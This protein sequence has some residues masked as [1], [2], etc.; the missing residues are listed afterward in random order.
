MG[1]GNWLPD[2]RPRL[3]ICFLHSAVLICEWRWM[4]GTYVSASSHLNYL[5]WCPKHCKHSVNA[6]GCFALYNAFIFVTQWGGVK[7]L[8]LS[9]LGVLSNLVSLWYPVSSLW[10]PCKVV[11]MWDFNLVCVVCPI[12]R[13]EA[14]FAVGTL[15]IVWSKQARV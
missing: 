4:I 13:W 12:V 11:Q 3:D 2:F 15:G 14:S 1:C 6:G 8:F 10:Y 5:E 9:V 7:F